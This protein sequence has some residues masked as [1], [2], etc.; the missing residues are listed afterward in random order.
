[1]RMT[2]NQHSSQV[3]LWQHSEASGREGPIVGRAPD[4]RI[5]L[6]SRLLSTF[7]TG[8]EYNP[9]VDEVSHCAKKRRADIDRGSPGDKFGDHNRSQEQCPDRFLTGALSFTG[10][11]LGFTRRIYAE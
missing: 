6:I 2:C 3:C 5:T 10:F 7:Q 9:R 11:K 8:V 1:M 4:L